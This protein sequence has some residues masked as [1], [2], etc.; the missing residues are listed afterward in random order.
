[1]QK[2]IKGLNN[3]NQR[4]LLLKCNVS[5]GSNESKL[6]FCPKHYRLGAISHD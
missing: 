2:R 1:M 4:I 5:Y 3:H 6:Q